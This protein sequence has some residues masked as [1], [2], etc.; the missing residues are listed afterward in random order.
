[1][2]GGGWNPFK[3]QLKSVVLSTILLLWSWLTRDKDGLSEIYIN[4]CSYGYRR[5]VY[6]P[7]LHNILDQKRNFVYQKPRNYSRRQIHE[8]TISLSF[9]GIILRVLSLEVSIYNVNIANQPLLLG[10]VKG[11]CE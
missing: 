10:G 3:R 8:R 7:L 1:M 4:K 9:L 5:C 11:D 6:L 2:G